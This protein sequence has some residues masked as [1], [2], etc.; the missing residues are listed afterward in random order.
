MT[1]DTW[2]PGGM[3]N[4]DAENKR[5]GAGGGQERRSQAGDATILLLDLYVLRCARSSGCERRPIGQP[6]SIGAGE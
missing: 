6:P 3:L 1:R 2:H 4:Y 5:E